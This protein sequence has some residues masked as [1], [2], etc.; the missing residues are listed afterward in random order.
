MDWMDPAG[1]IVENIGTPG[2][3]DA[4]AQ[5]LREVAPYDFAVIFGYVGSERPIDLFDDFPPDRRRLHVEEYQE[6][7][8]LLDP[9]FLITLE[10]AEPGL[11]RMREIAPDRFYQGEYYRNYYA[12]TGLAEEIGFLIRVNADLLIVVSLMRKEK[13]FSSAEV[14]A[15]RRVWPVIDAACRKHWK[16]LTFSD[17]AQA[18]SM[19]DRIESAFRSIGEGVLTARERQIVELTLRGHSADATGKLLSISS[20]TVRIHRR[21][22]YTKLRISSQ[23]ELFSFF[24]NAMLASG[25]TPFLA[26]ANPSAT[27]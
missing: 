5:G 18:S 26:S 2:F 6:G 16:D 10:P 24:I 13:R 11:W 25:T 3:G 21:N 4:L 23:G 22:I 17:R 27:A 1:R 12:Q 7:P 15:L 14:R 19:G 8:Y 20:G 9:F